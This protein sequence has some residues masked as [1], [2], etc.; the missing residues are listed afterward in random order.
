MTVTLDQAKA[1]GPIA[2]Q[3]V[4]RQN[5]VAAIAAAIA[6]ADWQITVLNAEQVGTGASMS[7]IVGPLDSAT[8]L[9][10]LQFA[11]Q[12]YQAQ[13]DALNAQLAAL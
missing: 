1:A 2:Q 8:T 5:K 7:L 4:E 11:L 10:C 6:A 3:I 9:Q 12:V 13:L